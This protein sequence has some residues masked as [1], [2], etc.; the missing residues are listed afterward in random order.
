MKKVVI[1]QGSPRRKGNSSLLA[2]ALQKGIETSVPNGVHVDIFSPVTHTIAP[3]IACERCCK[4]G[5][6]IQ[7]D[8]LSMLIEALDAADALIWISPLY[9]G[10]VTSQ[11]KAIIDRFQMLWARNMLAGEARGIRSDRSR[12]A[13]AFY[14]SAQDNPFSNE[15]KKAAALLPLKY[16]SNTAGFILE[17]DESSHLAIVGP[18]GPGEVSA[19]AYETAR[20]DA[21]SKV[22]MAIGKNQEA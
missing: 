20:E 13:L 4:T 6:C 10:G 2:A 19:V 16:A 14:I 11:L 22:V 5:E 12:P 21:I 1:I 8:D 7:S 17:N 18:D 15:V 3:C 9:F